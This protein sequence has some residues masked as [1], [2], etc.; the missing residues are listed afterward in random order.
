MFSD[1]KNNGVT[2]TRSQQNK[3]SRG[4]QIV[5]DITAEGGIRIEGKI[6]GTV[7]TPGKVVIGKTGE[8][9]GN[10]VCTNA[11]IEGSIKGT[12]RVNGTLT[13]R[14]S[15]RI[16]GEVTVA[17]LA[18]EPG[19]VFNATCTMDNAPMD[20]QKALRAKNENSDEN[21]SVKNL[22]SYRAQRSQKTTPEQAN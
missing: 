18:V 16:E 6:D 19:A 11:D 21:S 5:G 7:T 8:L 20:I 4:T 14:A 17:K 12:M 1:K 2:E 9:I 10:L 13:L 22:P 3:I 15:A